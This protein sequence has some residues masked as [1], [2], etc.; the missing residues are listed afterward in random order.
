MRK[1]SS[2][3][4]APPQEKTL[5][6]LWSQQPDRRF[7]RSQH[8]DPSALENRRRNVVVLSS[9]AALW[10]QPAKDADQGCPEWTELSPPP[11]PPPQVKNRG[12][13]VLTG[14]FWSR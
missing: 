12:S 1:K 5:Q 2:R 3:Q 10:L 8:S 11:P 9:Q 4:Q 14:G 6:L 7:W 13:H